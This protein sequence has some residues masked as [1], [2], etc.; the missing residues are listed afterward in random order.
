MTGK[1]QI[2]YTI[3]LA[4]ADVAEYERGKDKRLM[5]VAERETEFETMPRIECLSCRRIQLLKIVQSVLQKV[6]LKKEKLN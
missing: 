5:E 6:N 3:Q 1:Q 4:L 2:S